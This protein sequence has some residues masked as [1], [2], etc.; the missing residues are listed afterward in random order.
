M[1][2]HM[3]FIKYHLNL[4]PHQITKQWP[5]ETWYAH[6]AHDTRYQRHSDHLSR[7]GQTHI[8][9]SNTQSDLEFWN[10]PSRIIKRADEIN[11]GKSGR[12]LS[13]NTSPTAGQ[14]LPQWLRPNYFGQGSPLPFDLWPVVNAALQIFT[15][16]VKEWMAVWFEGLKNKNEHVLF[17]PPPKY[18]TTNWT[19]VYY[20]RANTTL[21]TS[22]SSLQYSKM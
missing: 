17:P 5:H 7:G 3:D 21:G 8:R 15:R 22:G 10:A 12:V 2:S 9:R 19:N 20:L 13:V 6:A 16:T 1:F 11:E 14:R 4:E 18:T